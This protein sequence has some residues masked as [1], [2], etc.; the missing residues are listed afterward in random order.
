MR[1]HWQSSND[2]VVL[3]SMSKDVQALIGQVLQR[4]DQAGGDGGPTGRGGR[5]DRRFVDR[6]SAMSIAAHADEAGQS[7]AL[8]ARRTAV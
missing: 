3:A 2:L 4:P 5:V 1:V 6:R 8:V 7:P